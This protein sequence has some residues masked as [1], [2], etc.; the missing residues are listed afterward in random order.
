V[1]HFGEI[2]PMLT[3]ELPLVLYCDGPECELS[4]GHPDI[5]IGAGFKKFLMR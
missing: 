2:A 3:R 4:H 5:D 1:R